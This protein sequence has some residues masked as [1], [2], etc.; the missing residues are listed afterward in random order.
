MTMTVILWFL[1]GC[2]KPVPPAAAV[3]AEGAAPEAP[4]VAAPPPRD[5][6]LA[7]TWVQTSAELDALTRTV[8]RAAHH[9][10]DR[11]LAD[12]TWTAA[13]EQ[14][15]ALDGLQPAI[16]VDVDETVLDNSPNQARGVLDGTHFEKVSWG[17]WVAESQAPAVA[18]AAEFLSAAKAKGV[19]V[20]YVSNR[21]IDQEEPTRA[22]LAAAG[23][24]DTDDLEHFFFRPA[25]GDRSKTTRRRTIEATHR[26][27]LM[28]GDNL[29]DFVE[30]EAPDRAARAELVDAHADWWGVR[31]F[32]LP[33]PM[34]GSWDDVLHGYEHPDA[35]TKH[36]QRREALDPMR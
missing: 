31:W 16:V 14:T 15:G 13:L 11:A 7:V 4:V 6:L 12:P 28:F 2:G 29:F 32:M 18:G 8:Y 27:V 10:L 5:D 35:G 26:I 19:D 30:P 25:E 3:E 23:F 20:F 24:P 21:S 33:N 36:E 17:A 1:V 34:Y 9:S 22:N